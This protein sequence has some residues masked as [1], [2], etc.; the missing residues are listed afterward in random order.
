MGSY[1]LYSPTLLRR[2]VI[3]AAEGLSTSRQHTLKIRVLDKKRTEATNTVVDVD[4]FVLV[5]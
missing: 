5:R 1:D 2:K 4:G 3:Y